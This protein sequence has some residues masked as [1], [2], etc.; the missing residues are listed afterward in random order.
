MSPQITADIS[1]RPIVALVAGIKEA[2]GRIMGHAGAFTIAGEPGAKAKMAALEN[3]G[4]MLVNHPAKFGQLLKA[5]LEGIE[6]ARSLPGNG[7]SSTVNM[8]GGQRRQMH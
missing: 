4:A 8:L 5:R 3:A 2:T 7:D 1:P 6:G